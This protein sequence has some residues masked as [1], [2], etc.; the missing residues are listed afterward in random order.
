M[1]KEI[2]LSC[3]YLLIVIKDGL[4]HSDHNKWCYSTVGA[5]LWDHRYCYQSDIII[6]LR[7]F[8]SSP[9]KWEARRLFNG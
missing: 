7:Q 1:D 3:Y 8:L 6:T 4:V 5:A 9:V 2:W